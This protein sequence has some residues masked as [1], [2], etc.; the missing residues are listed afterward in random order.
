MCP[1]A[2][3]PQKREGAAAIQEV[4]AGIRRSHGIAPTRK[5]AADADVLRDMG[6]CV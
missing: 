4:M 3:P 1:V 6:P 5:R 2:W